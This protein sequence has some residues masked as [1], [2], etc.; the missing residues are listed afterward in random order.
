MQ[1]AVKNEI[2]WRRAVIKSAIL[3]R[4]IGRHVWVRVGAVEKCGHVNSA[5]LECPEPAIRVN[6]EFKDVTRLGPDVIKYLQTKFPKGIPRSLFQDVIHLKDI[7]FLEEYAE[8]LPL[9][10][11]EEWDGGREK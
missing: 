10:S 6:H 5:D 7:E 2:K 8:N 9:L 11:W 1:T 4:E 3:H